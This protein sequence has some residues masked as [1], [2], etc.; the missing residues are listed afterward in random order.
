MLQKCVILLLYR[1]P[2]F[3]TQTH[4]S[5]KSKVL[6]R[7]LAWFINLLAKWYVEFLRTCNHVDL[8]PWHFA[9]PAKKNVGGVHLTRSPTN[10]TP[11][12][13]NA[14]ISKSL[15]FF[16]TQCPYPEN[17]IPPERTCVCKE[18][19]RLRVE[20]SDGTHYAKEYPVYHWGL[21]FTS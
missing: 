9:R 7:E 19:R 8:P 21:R 3:Y 14:Q 17:T 18:T 16:H 11:I 13:Q 10:N 1:P 12:C 6:I 20:T 15:Y 2:Y 4:Q 5:H